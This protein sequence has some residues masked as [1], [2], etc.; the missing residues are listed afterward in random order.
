MMY[1]AL[2]LPALH[3]VPRSDAQDT[4]A[5][6]IPH[7]RWPDPADAGR[8]HRDLPEMARRPGRL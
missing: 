8:V 6:Q 3:R 7:L 2:R 5:H 1:P 4:R